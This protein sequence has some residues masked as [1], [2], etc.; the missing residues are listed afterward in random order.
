MNE[1]MT[2]SGILRK[3]KDLDKIFELKLEHIKSLNN[4]SQKMFYSL[5]VFAGAI[6]LFLFQIG[7]TL[8]MT[9]FERIILFLGLFISQ[10]VLII[11]SHMWLQNKIKSYY[12]QLFYE[13]LVGK[14]D[15]IEGISMEE[16]KRLTEHLKK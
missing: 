12:N 2:E 6:V 8:S 7:I 15:N 9:K 4:T 5:L 13:L 1:S 14:M 16:Y 3:H 10:F 11:T